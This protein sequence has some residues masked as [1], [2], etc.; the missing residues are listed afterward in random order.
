M[1]TYSDDFID[2][3]NNRE[4]GCS[5]LEEDLTRYGLKYILTEFFEWLRT[6]CVII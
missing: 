6:Q 5:T 1:K 4:D 2:S 3:Y